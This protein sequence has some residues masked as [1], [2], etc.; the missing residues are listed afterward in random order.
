MPFA[1]PK[2]FAIATGIDI[3]GLFILVG[4]EKIEPIKNATA[5]VSPKARPSANM[6]Q[7]MIP[8]FEYGKIIIP[9]SCGA[10]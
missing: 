2:L 3:V 4:R 6:I 7:P 1:S 8:T 9:K 10:R 5:I